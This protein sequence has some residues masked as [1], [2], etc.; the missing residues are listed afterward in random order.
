MLVLTRKKL[1]GILVGDEIRITVVKIDGNQVRIGIE[2]P[3]EIPVMREE[4]THDD[5]ARQARKA[6]DSSEHPVRKDP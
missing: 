6:W 3:E 4:L 2:A 1:E 5:E